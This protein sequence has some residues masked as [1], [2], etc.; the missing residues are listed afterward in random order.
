MKPEPEDK[1]IQQL[2]REILSEGINPAELRAEKKAF[3]SLYFPK[4]P[5]F[6]FGPMWTPAV[7]FAVA[8][9]AVF[10]VRP[11]LFISPGASTVEEAPAPAA[12]TAAPAAA[13]AASVPQTAGQQMSKN[14][15]ISHVSSEMGPTVV[16]QK[17]VENV[18][19]AVVWVFPKPATA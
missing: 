15:I 3:I 6:V 7:A 18:P 19:V 1:R 17:R 11:E 2:Y 4:K 5:F 12:M 10:V 9:F 16:Y 8:A 13:P 14:I